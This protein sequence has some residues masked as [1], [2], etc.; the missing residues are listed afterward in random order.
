MSTGARRSDTPPQPTRTSK[1]RYVC[2]RC[3]HHTTLLPWDSPET[4]RTGCSTCNSIERHVRKGSVAGW[5]L[6]TQED[7]RYVR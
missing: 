3:A 6:A 4:V 7:D 2:G 5:Q 1:K